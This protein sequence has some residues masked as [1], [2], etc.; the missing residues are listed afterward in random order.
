ME[1]LAPDKR[2]SYYVPNRTWHCTVFDNYREVNHLEDHAF[3]C[4]ATVN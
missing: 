4:T 2:K 1:S 3:D